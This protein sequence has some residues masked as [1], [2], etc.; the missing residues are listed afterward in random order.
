LALVVPL[1]IR[2]QPAPIGALRIELTYHHID[3]LVHTGQSSF[4]MVAMGMITF[5]VGAILWGYRKWVLMPLNNLRTSVMAINPSLLEAN[6]PES[7]DEFGQINT[8]LNELLA[9][10]KAEGAAQRDA[11]ATQPSE[12]RILVEGLLRRFMPDARLLL[13]DKENRLICDT[14]EESPIALEQPPHLLDLV[15]D[16]G[17]AALIGSAFKNETDVAS[18]PVLFQ[19]QPYIATVIPLA[20][21]VSKIVR[22][23]I[24]LKTIS[25]VQT[26]K[27]AV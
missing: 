3:D 1:K 13:I 2:G 24:V 7:D 27:E 16:S 8:S 21:G 17:F 6:L 11:L 20:Q 12:E 9:K 25:D 4:H 26:K 19:D 15:T 22:T 18:G 14:A 10:L 23:V 5:S